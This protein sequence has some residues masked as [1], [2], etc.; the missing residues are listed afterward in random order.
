MLRDWRRGIRKVA[1]QP[2][3]RIKRVFSSISA[4]LIS[5]V[6]RGSGSETRWGCGTVKVGF[7][8]DVSFEFSL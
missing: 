5:K 7:G 8:Y 4:G 3:P 2:A 6:K 1:V